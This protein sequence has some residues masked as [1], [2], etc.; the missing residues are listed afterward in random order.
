MVLNQTHIAAVR[1]NRKVNEMPNEIFPAHLKDE[2]MAY[3]LAI[4]MTEVLDDRYGQKA[5]RR[6]RIMR[7]RR[8]GKGA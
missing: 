5:R 1:C 6:Q 2:C 3:A 7:N 4:G 8:M